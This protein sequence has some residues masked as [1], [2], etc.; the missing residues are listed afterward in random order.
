MVTLD[1]ESEFL[2]ECECDTTTTQPTSPADILAPADSCKIQYI[3]AYI[4]FDQ[5]Q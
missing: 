4:V 2:P 3:G 1:Q 5:V